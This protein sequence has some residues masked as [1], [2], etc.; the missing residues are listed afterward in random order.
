SPEQRLVFL[1]RALTTTGLDPREGVPLLAGLI[2]LSLPPGRYPPIGGSPAHR[3][4]RLMATL[5]GWLLAAAAVQPAVLGGADLMWAAPS[6]I[7]LLELLGPQAATAR[8]LLLYTARPE[9][10]CAW[11]PRSNLTM[12]TLNRLDRQHVRQMIASRS[13]STLHE[14]VETLVERSDGV[15]LFAEELTSLV[16]DA[17]GRFVQIEVPATLQDLLAARLRRGRPA[18]PPPPPPPPPRP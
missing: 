10:R 5:A 9:F 14:L 8:V 13:R 3:R 15:P 6:T 4:E 12:V 7:E 2:G 1:E 18:P 17:A 11:S 16:T